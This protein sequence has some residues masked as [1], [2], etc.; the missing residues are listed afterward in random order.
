LRRI[1]SGLSHRDVFAICFGKK[2][3]QLCF[4]HSGIHTFNDGDDTFERH[5]TANLFLADADFDFSRTREKEKVR[6]ADAINCGNE[7]DGDAA[8]DFADVIE[9][10]HDLNEAENGADDA[11]C[12]REAT[13]GFEHSGDVV[14]VFG[15]IVELEFHHFANFLWL[16]AVH[17]EH[18]GFFEKRI[19]HG[20]EFRVE[21][22]DAALAGF[23]GESDDFADELARV[24]RRI[25]KNLARLLIAA[26]TTLSGNC[27]MIAPRVPPR[28]IKAAVG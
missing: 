18:E 3:H 21:R 5:F 11:D 19:G 16:G 26:K 8:S 28:T 1:A 17:S 23:I 9:V 13:S 10:L 24:A 6:H 27:S 4:N 14:L 25:T 22:N 15:L 12:R 2:A 7:G 20:A